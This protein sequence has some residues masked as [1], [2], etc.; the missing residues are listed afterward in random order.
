MA[1]VLLVL[2]VVLVLLNGM[3]FLVVVNQGSIPEKAAAASSAPSGSRGTANPDLHSQKLETLIQNVQTVSKSLGDLSRK[4]DDLQ[5]KVSLSST[6]NLPPPAPITAGAAAV[7]NVG[8]APARP[9][10]T[11]PPPIRTGPTEISRVGAPRSPAPAATKEE[12]DDEAEVP[13]AQMPKPG[14]AP[15]QANGTPAPDATPDSAGGETPAGTAAGQPASPADG[16]AGGVPGGEG[17]QE[18]LEGEQAR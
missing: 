14:S 1:K 15:S 13:A 18:K 17:A 6:R 7:G 3:T 9:A 4:V 8:M 12:D 2:A 5:R 11:P 10:R 16:A